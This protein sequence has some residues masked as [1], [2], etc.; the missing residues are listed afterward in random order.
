MD[1]SKRLDDPRGGVPGG[2]PTC[3][4]F[5]AVGETDHVHI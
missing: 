4:P 2:D 5:L 1:V 3:T